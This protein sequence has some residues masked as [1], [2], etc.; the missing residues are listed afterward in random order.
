MKEFISLLQSVVVSPGGVLTILSLL[1]IAL[2]WLSHWTTKK[3]TEVNVM[4]R[5]MRQNQN[6]Q[7]TKIDVLSNKIDAL[8]DK[9]DAKM[10]ARF[11]KVDKRFDKVDARFDK[12]DKRFEKVDERF[13]RVEVHFDIVEAKIE[14]V[15][16]KQ[17]DNVST[18]RGEIIALK[19]RLEC[20]DTLKLPSR[21][22]S[23]P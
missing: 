6:L 3:F 2:I 13:E 7:D 10:D 1:I 22:V 23:V 20:S 19:T 4:M 17:N 15:K 14:E 16:D 12:V 5:F 8:S 21:T 11:D 18:I 9:M